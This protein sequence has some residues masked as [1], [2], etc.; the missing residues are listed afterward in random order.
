KWGNPA[1]AQEGTATYY[2]GPVWSYYIPSAADQPNTFLMAEARDVKEVAKVSGGPPPLFRDM[3]RL[4][5]ATDGDRHF[6]MLLYPPFLFNDD[7]EPLFAA[8]RAKTRQPISWLLGDGLQ[9]ASVSLHFSGE[10]YLEMRMLGS[11]DKEPFKLASELRDRMN[12]IPSSLEDYFI[13]LTPPPYW[14]KLSFRVPSMINTLHANMRVGVESDQAILNA[15]LPPA[16]GHN[17]VLGGELLMASTPGAV[18]ASAGPQAPAGGGGVKSVEDALQVKTTYSFDQ[19][20]LEFA[21]RDLAADVKDSTKFDFA[22]KII[23]PDLEKDGITR[24]MSVRDF[25]QTDATVADI[26]TALVMKTSTA[27]GPSE[28]DH[29]LVWVIAADPENPTKQ[30]IL[31]TTRA[32]AAL[33][34][35]VLPAP[36]V[37]KNA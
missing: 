5:R 14:K 12:Q 22:I 20:S 30:I 28:P 3:E 2:T 36:F 32:A 6:T 9:A 19:Q 27:K 18:V 21:M 8:E 29:K 15:V 37:P 23:G 1:A 4:R 24:N 13:L 17:L 7:G 31:I 26:L 10:T 34:K 25:K 33:K 16:A 11:L 35:Y